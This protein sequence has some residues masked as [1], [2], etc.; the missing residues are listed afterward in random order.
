MSYFGKRTEIKKMI[1]DDGMYLTLGEFK[2]HFGICDKFT[3]FWKFIFKYD[4]GK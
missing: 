3:C 4:K 2:K 1:D